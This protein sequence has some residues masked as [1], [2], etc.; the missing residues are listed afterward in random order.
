MVPLLYNGITG[1]WVI[2][3]DQPGEIVVDHFLLGTIDMIPMARLLKEKSRIQRTVGRLVDF[4]QPFLA[5]NV[6][7]GIGHISIQRLPVGI[8][9][10]SDVMDALHPAFDFEAVHT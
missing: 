9:N 6:L 8:H 3:H 7:C 5:E 2:I 4:V 10:R 1:A